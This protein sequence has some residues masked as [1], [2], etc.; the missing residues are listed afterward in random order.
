MSD[1]DLSLDLILWRHAD[2]EEG[3][4]DASR[5]LTRRGRKQAA[6]MAQWLEQQMPAH[7]RLLSSPAVRARQTAEA[8]QGSVKLDER[9]AVGASASDVLAACGWPERGGT[10]VAVGHQPTLG[11]I[12]A[13]LLCGRELDWTLR[14]GS[15]CWLSRRPRGENGGVMLRA[16]IQPDMLAG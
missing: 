13:L 2:A 7:Y 8:L 11:R 15:I 3:M 10:T 9:L 12:A 5:P 1:S 4:P 6:R 14:K 16:L